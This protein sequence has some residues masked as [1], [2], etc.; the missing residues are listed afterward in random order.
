MI[1]VQVKPFTLLS[2]RNPNFNEIYFS[3]GVK[4]APGK[5][6]QGLKNKL[7]TDIFV[8][9][10]VNSDLSL[11]RKTKSIIAQTAQRL[12]DFTIEQAGEA[13]ECFEDT[14][15]EIKG[16]TLQSRIKSKE[17]IY[18][19]ICRRIIQIKKKKEELEKRLKG[20]LFKN[21]KNKLI[22]LIKENNNLYT[23]FLSGDFETVYDRLGD[24]LGTRI[25]IDKPTPEN[26]NKIVQKLISGIKNGDFS[27]TNIENYAINAEHFY[28]SNRQVDR[29]I[30]ACSDKGLKTTYSEGSKTSGYITTQ[31]DITYKNGVKS[32]LQI[33]G[34]EVHEAAENEHLL[35][36]MRERKNIAKG[37]KG[38]ENLLEPVYKALKVLDSNSALKDS[39][40]DY[41]REYYKNKRN[42]EMQRS[43]SEV[44][45]PKYVP[46]ALDMSNITRINRKLAEMQTYE[47]EALW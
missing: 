2:N 35:H 27:I 11:S 33:R 22:D 46:V 7:S 36:N 16:V 9:G 24:T 41:L 31:L 19:K 12:Y 42:I 6:F 4:A 37:D 14:F 34:K 26:I 13:V 15:L 29:I 20:V 5:S 40:D 32:E 43:N 10:P 45:L 25:I 38:I 3:G 8:K 28:F 30:K 1:K 23:L 17:N 47:K 18:E 44:T 21:E 39:Y